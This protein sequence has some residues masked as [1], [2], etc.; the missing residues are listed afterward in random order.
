MIFPG[1]LQNY[2]N[3]LY[4]SYDLYL[5]CYH[6]YGGGIITYRQFELLSKMMTVF[7]LPQS[8]EGRDELLQGWATFYHGI[9]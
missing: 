6:L 9:P 2:L 7:R 3:Y 4:K 1:P 5:Y 8:E